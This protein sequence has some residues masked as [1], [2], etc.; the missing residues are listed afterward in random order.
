MDLGGETQVRCWDKDGD[1]VALQ[2]SP[3]ES[4]RQKSNT[5]MAFG[6]RREWLALALQI[7][8][9]EPW[10]GPGQMQ[11]REEAGGLAER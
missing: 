2:G 3:K 9:Q 11:N 1:I 6:K 5:L 4:K 8:G 7:V 10:P